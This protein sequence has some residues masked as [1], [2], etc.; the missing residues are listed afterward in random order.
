MR[1][2]VGDFI[3]QRKFL[4]NVSTLLGVLFSKVTSILR[5]LKRSTTI[6]NKVDIMYYNGLIYMN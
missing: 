6:C 3:T 2:E 5:K 4:L 1:A